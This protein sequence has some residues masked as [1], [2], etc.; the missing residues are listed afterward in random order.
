DEIGEVV[1]RGAL[2]QLPH[3]DVVEHAEWW[4][5]CVILRDQRHRLAITDQAPV[6]IVDQCRF[7][8]TAASKEGDALTFLHRLL[9]VDKVV[10]V[11]PAD[12]L[13]LEPDQCHP[14]IKSS[15]RAVSSAV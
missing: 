4:H 13:V 11:L 8:C 7:A 1:E 10:V 14:S 2:V 5:Q 9:Y 3:V 15:K 6:E 12:G